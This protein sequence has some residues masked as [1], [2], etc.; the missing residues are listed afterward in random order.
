MY[1]GIPKELILV[2]YKSF[3]PASAQHLLFISWGW[4]SVG[5]RQYFVCQRTSCAV[6]VVC[7]G[8]ETSLQSCRYSAT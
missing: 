5:G 4:L 8:R 7:L 3:K 2:Q 1:F 6:S